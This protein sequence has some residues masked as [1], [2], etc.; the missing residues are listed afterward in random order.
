[1]LF[2]SVVVY[3]VYCV[4]ACWLSMCVYTYEVPVFAVFVFV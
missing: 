1:M 3:I 2:D 4:G